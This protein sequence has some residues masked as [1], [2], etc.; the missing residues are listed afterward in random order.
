MIVAM[1]ASKRRIFM[2][3]A[4]RLTFALLLCYRRER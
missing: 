1:M 2:T 3:V 4:P